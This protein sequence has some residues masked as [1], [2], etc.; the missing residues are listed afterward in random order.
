MGSSADGTAELSLLPLKAGDH[1][2]KVV[3]EGGSTSHAL[4]VGQSLL[5]PSEEGAAL[6]IKAEGQNGQPPLVHSVVT[7]QVSPGGAAGCVARV[8]LSEFLQS[9]KAD[10]ADAHE[11]PTPAGDA[12][13]TA[14]TVFVRLYTRRPRCRRAAVLRALEAIGM[15]VDAQAVGAFPEMFPWWAIF[16]ESASLQPGL[17]ATR[18]RAVRY[19]LS[20]KGDAPVQPAV[21]TAVLAGGAVVRQGRVVLRGVRLMKALRLT[22]AAAAGWANLGG[23]IGQTLAAN[24][25]D[26]GDTSTA[27]ATAAGGW[28]GGLAGGGVGALAMASVGEASVAGGLVVCGALSASGAVAGAGLAYAAKKAL[29]PP[30][31]GQ[32]R[33][34]EF[35]DCPLRLL[36][37]ADDVFNLFDATLEFPVE[38]DEQNGA[39][40]TEADPGQRLAAAG[41]YAVRVQAGGPQLKA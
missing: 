7:V 38:D 5:L 25:L 30:S 16:D 33:T 34:A 41:W 29:E 6:C 21:M 37:G 32:D 31:G 28:A 22:R 39:D 10:K 23:M 40:A 13:P 2:W 36:G 14:G 17:C 12:S 4:Y 15:R 20:P 19:R 8:P 3:A 18:A 35:H 26:D 24:M 27:V 1:L 11:I 9:G